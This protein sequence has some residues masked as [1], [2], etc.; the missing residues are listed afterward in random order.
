[1][2][3]FFP[4]LAGVVTGEAALGRIEKLWKKFVVEAQGVRCVSDQPWVTIAETSEL[5]IALSAMG[6]LELSQIVF[7]WILDKRYEDGSFWCGY[8]YPDMVIWPGEKI[9]WTNG[10]VLLAA[11]AL[12][13]LTPG[14]RLFDHDYWGI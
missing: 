9:A 2:D 14:G 13:G 11:D 1:M 10:V 4:V 8:T 12:Y 7:S 3:W 6:K 5:C